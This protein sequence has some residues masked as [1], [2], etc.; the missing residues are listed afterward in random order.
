M[1]KDEKKNMAN[2]ESSFKSLNDDFADFL[3]G[4]DEFWPKFA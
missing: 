3:D 2:L 4:M 1:R